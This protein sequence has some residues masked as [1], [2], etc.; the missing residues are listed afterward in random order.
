V[1]WIGPL[2]GADAIASIAIAI[3]I[4]RTRGRVAA[5]CGALISAGALVGLALA[6]TTGLLSWHEDV[7][8]PAVL[9]A[10]A[11]ELVAVATL[12]PLAL[13]APTRASTRVPPRAVAAAGL[14]AVA[15]LHLAAAGDEWTD[16]RAVF[17]LFVALAAASLALALRLAQGLDRWGWAAVSVLAGVP[18]IGYLVSRTTGLP[19]DPGDVGDWANP[20]GLAALA[21]EAALV[22]LAVGRLR[23]PSRGLRRPMRPLDLTDRT[24]PGLRGTA[25]ATATPSPT[26]E[27]CGCA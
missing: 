3:A 13:S 20:V 17:W 4:V 21:V 2:F 8:R 23:I 11:S 5:A 7:L 15:A 10:I 24:R 6:S 25:T 22:R 19:G 16:A 18:L 14:V 12:T 27:R 1:P 26:R 9:I